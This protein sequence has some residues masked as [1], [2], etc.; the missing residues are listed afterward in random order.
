MQ[1]SASL[2]KY[3]YL[4]NLLSRLIISYLNVFCNNIIDTYY[5]E[6]FLYFTQSNK[7]YLVEIVDIM[8]TKL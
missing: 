4:E 1:H 6:L 2:I 3:A 7:K 8:P 5:A